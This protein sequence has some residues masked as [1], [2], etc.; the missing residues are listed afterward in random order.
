MMRMIGAIIRVT[1]GAAGVVWAEEIK[2]PVVY[3]SNRTGNDAFDGPS[4]KQDATGKTGPELSEGYT[5]V[6]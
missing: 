2:L 4:E 3:V 6:R 1:V 5:P